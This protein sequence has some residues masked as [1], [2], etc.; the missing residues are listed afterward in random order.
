MILPKTF[1]L[2]VNLLERMEPIYEFIFCAKLN[3]NSKIDAQEAV[4]ISR[5]MICGLKITNRKFALKNIAKK[6]AAR[7][8]KRQYPHVRSEMK[9][10]QRILRE[11]LSSGMSGEERHRRI[12]NKYE[13]FQDY[14]YLYF[15]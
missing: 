7:F 12:F 1:C 15:L 4:R 14:T 9:R 10:K 11:R 5:V 13:T 3:E 2:A 8:A 6:K